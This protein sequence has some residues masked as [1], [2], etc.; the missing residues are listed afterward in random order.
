MA[1]PFRDH[2]DPQ[3]AVFSPGRAGGTAGRWGAVFGLATHAAKEGKSQSQEEGSPRHGL[4][5]IEGEVRIGRVGRSPSKSGGLESAINLTWS[6]PGFQ[7]TR[8]SGHCGQGVPAGSFAEA[9][10]FGGRGFA[11]HELHR[12]QFASFRP[13]S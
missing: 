6:R 10:G 5:R 13:E 4:A 1:G 9:V 11:I 12:N 7:H 3:F 8:G 2:R